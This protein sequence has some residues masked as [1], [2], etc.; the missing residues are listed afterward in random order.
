MNGPRAPRRGR[1]ADRKAG[2]GEP[3]PSGKLP[4]RQLGALLAE[5]GPSPPEVLLGPAVGEDACAI[6]I[7]GG[8]LVAATDPITLTAGDIGRFSVVVNANDVAVMGVRPRWFL[9]TVLLPPGT[10]SDLVTEIF[11]SMRRSLDE[12]GASLVGGHTEITEAVCRPIVVGQMIGVSDDGAFVSS[13]GARPGDRVLQVGAAPIEGAAVLAREAGDRLGGVDPV[14]REAARI[15]LHDPGISVVAPALLAAD[16]GATAMHDPTEGGLASGLH[17]LAAASNVRVR[18]DRR[19]VVWFEPALAV[20]RALAADRWATLASGAL[21]AT[22]PAQVA[23]AALASLQAAG[24]LP[25][26]IGTVEVGTGVIDE[27]G[28]PIVWPERD[29]VAR[30]LSL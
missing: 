21:L 5:F 12:V 4:W 17:E 8:T 13:G 24:H 15:S 26:I 14:Q 7:R 22:V 23:D 25:A 11:A 1:H 20:C 27:K 6:D 2:T 28:D 19:K 10:V 16:L 30:I 9:A 29:E 3:F 18:I